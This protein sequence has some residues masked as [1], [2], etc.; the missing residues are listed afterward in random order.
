[1]IRIDFLDKISQTFNLNMS[2]YDNDAILIN[3]HSGAKIVLS[4]DTTPEY[5]EYTV[6]FSTQHR[7]FSSLEKAEEYIRLIISDEVLPIE[8]FESNRAR[9]GSE[10][11]KNDFDDITTEKLAQIFGYTVEYLSQF[12]FEV[13]SWSGKYDLKRTKVSELS[14]NLQNS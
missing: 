7:H 9:F 8:F 6:S 2:Y 13:H 11:R 1:M 4:D 12:E 5:T 10:I 3:P 14:K